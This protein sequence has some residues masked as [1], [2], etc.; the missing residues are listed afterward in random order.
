[1]AILCGMDGLDWI[2][3]GEVRYRALYGA[4]KPRT[5][6]LVECLNYNGGLLGGG[7]SHS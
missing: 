7:V 1:M 4:N 2:P 5:G 6:R 3:P